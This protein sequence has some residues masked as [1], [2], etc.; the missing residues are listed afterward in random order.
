MSDEELLGRRHLRRTMEDSDVNVD[1][2]APRTKDELKEAKKRIREETSGD[3]E[4]AFIIQALSRNDWNVTKAAQDTGMQ[5]P[6]FQALMRKRGVR[7]KDIRP[8]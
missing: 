1:R 4:R 8:K 3:V 2:P 7:L 5:R 6:N